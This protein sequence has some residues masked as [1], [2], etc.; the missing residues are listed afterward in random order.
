MQ[1]MSIASIFS[2]LFLYCIPL[3]PMLPHGK[4]LWTTEQLQNLNKVVF[5]SFH[6]VL[7]FQEECCQHIIMCPQ[8][9]PQIEHSSKG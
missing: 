3:Y 9:L 6:F 2:N 8:V 7:T 5:S 1:G 4:A